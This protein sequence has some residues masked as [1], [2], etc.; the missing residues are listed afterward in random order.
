MDFPI[1]LTTKKVEICVIGAII[2]AFIWKLPDFA[3]LYREFP[4]L[5]V[6]SLLFLAVSVSFLLLFLRP[7]AIRSTALDEHHTAA[8]DTHETMR[9]LNEQNRLSIQLLDRQL[10]AQEQMTRLIEIELSL[11]PPQ[12]PL[13]KESDDH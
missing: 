3:P 10:A 11:K 4:V 6:L 2:V 9:C 8:S 13:R 7:L 1:K 12:C 5:T